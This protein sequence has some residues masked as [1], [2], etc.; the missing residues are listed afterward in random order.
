MNNPGDLL[1]SIAPIVKNTILYTLKFQ[2][3]V[4]YSKCYYQKIIIV[5]NKKS[6]Q[7][8]L[9]RIDMFMAWIVVMLS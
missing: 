3:T 6:G 2:E 9:E 7:K 5:I 4:S 8:L 1:Y